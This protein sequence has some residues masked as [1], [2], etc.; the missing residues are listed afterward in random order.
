MDKLTEFYDYLTY[1]KRV[2]KHTIKAYETDLSQFGVFISSKYGELEIEQVTYRHMRG[3][4]LA[5]LDEG[6][7]ERSV[8]RK[9]ATLKTFY[10]FLKQKEYTADNP[11]QKLQSLKTGKKLPSFIKMEEMDSVL[12]SSRFESDFNGIRDRMVLELLYGT[13]IRQ[14][15][16]L[17]LKC[18][19]VDLQQKVIK[20]TGKRNKQRLIP[21]NDTLCEI[22]SL[23]LNSRPIV[24][25]DY[26][27]V[28]KSGTPAYPMLIY[29]IVEKHL[30]YTNNV[31]KKS[32]HTLRHTFATHLLNE[33]AALNDIKEL[34]G[35]ANL[36]ATQVY[37]QQSLERL[38]KV[39][40]QAHPKSGENEVDK[41]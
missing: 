19:H 10:R 25:H 23:Y 12:D 5:L 38:K 3:W 13:G 2:S 4:V 9:V 30:S 22:F 6:V 32:P 27:I 14:A 24:D 31:D 8:N 20:V 34:M 11:A 17:S 21:C 29:R 33:G 26:L 41:N 39:F 16:L 28:T 15:E 35:H 18:V 36:A 37:T 1:Q 40:I 7:S